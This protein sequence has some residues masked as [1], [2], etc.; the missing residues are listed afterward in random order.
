MVF[1]KKKYQT[2][3][4]RERYQKD[5]EFRERVIKAVCKS[6]RKTYQ[7]IRFDVLELVGKTKCSKC[8]FNDWRAL[9]L[10]HKNGKGFTDRKRLGS[11]RGFNQYYLNHPKEAKKKL[12]VLCANCNWIKRSKNNETSLKHNV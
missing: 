4:M 5:P 12:Q 10:D 6:K 9:Q 3:Y 2:K 11:G 7:Q 1:D 8:G